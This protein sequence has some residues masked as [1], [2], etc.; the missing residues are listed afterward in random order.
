M[1]RDK[2]NKV[3]K[4]LGD[5]ASFRVCLMMHTSSLCVSSMYIVPHI[6]HSCHQVF[7]YTLTFFHI[8]VFIATCFHDEEFLS[9][10]LDSIVL[11]L[12]VLDVHCTSPQAF[13]TYSFLECKETV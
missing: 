4:Q 12:P 8:G 2:R 5:A 10:E 3:D 1:R 9:F 7:L 11:T 13:Q 6:R